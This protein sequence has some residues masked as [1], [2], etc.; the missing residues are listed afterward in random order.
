M[1]RLNA[2]STN[3]ES[4]PTTIKAILTENKRVSEHGFLQ[5]ELDRAK[6]NILTSL[7]SQVKEKGKQNSGRFVN[8]YIR[9]FL[10]SEPIPGIEWEYRA[11][12]ECFR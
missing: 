7:E 12:K 3:K 10:Q 8:Q 1:Y 6:Q 4:L 9:H 2:A 5:S 11:A